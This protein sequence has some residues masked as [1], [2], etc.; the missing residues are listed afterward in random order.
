MSILSSPFVTPLSNKMSEDLTILT[1]NSFLESDWMCSESFEGECSQCSELEQLHSDLEFNIKRIMSSKVSDQH[2]EGCDKMSNV[3]FY[4]MDSVIYTDMLSRFG[5]RDPDRTT[6]EAVVVV[7]GP[8]QTV[9]TYDLT[10]T[11]FTH[12]KPFL[13]YFTAPPEPHH[14]NSPSGHHPNY[15]SNQPLEILDISKEDLPQILSDYSRSHLLFVYTKWC[16]FCHITRMKLEASLRLIT[17]S[18]P[19][20]FLSIDS[21]LNDDLRGTEIRVKDVPMIVVI[22]KGQQTNFPISPSRSV[23]VNEILTFIEQNVDHE[24]WYSDRYQAR[25]VV[26]AAVPCAVWQ[27][28]PLPEAQPADLMLGHTMVSPIDNILLDNVPEIDNELDKLLAEQTDTHTDNFPNVVRDK[29]VQSE[30]QRRFSRSYACRNIPHLYKA[31]SVGSGISP[32]E[33][34]TLTLK[35]ITEI[36]TFGC[37]RGEEKEFWVFMYDH[38]YKASWSD[39]PCQYLFVANEIG[40][41]HTIVPEKYKNLLKYKQVEAIITWTKKRDKMQDMLGPKY[42]ASRYIISHPVD[43]YHRF[44]NF[45]CYNVNAEFKSYLLGE[46]TDMCRFP[47][48]VVNRITIFNNN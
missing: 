16:G 26:P 30:G 25:E 45:N 7:N 15:D 11:S 9:A 17:T 46:C 37:L 23:R 47:C 21:D 19:I 1:Q 10:N 48:R 33:P 12:F 36:S 28:E 27:P 3:K 32:Y 40:N 44:H 22:S 35:L 31:L 14:I 5:I 29:M 41:Y 20:S 43:E 13:D 38:C 6:T 8:N 39:L 2:G 4:A 24:V 42:V 34:T 18:S